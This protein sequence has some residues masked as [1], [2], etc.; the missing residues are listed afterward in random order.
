LPDSQPRRRAGGRAA[1]KTKALPGTASLGQHGSP[2]RRRQPAK[3]RGSSPCTLGHLVL[4]RA[5]RILA[6][7]ARLA[8]PTSGGGR[9]GHS[10][11]EPPNFLSIADPAGR[12]R[13]PLSL[14]ARRRA[15]I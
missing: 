8:P 13:E 4:R 2:C 9:G 5:T 10:P 7:G 11:R 15:R 3:A 1:R 12:S 6:A 14:W